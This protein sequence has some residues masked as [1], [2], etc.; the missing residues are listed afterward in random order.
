M[1]DQ[2][3]ASAQ[4]HSTPVAGDSV[5]HLLYDL[6]LRSERGA[7][8]R[9][10]NLVILFGVFMVLMTFGFV[11]LWMR[12]SDIIQSSQSAQEAGYTTRRMV[13][14]RDDHLDRRINHLAGV[15]VKTNELLGVQ[16]KS[17]EETTRLLQQALVPKGQARPVSLVDVP[18]AL[19]NIRQSQRLAHPQKSGSLLP[20]SKRSRRSLLADR[21]PVVAPGER[22]VA[23]DVHPPELVPYK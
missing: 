18:A 5:V 11:S 1:P 8:V 16:T 3:H 7:E 23:P 9:E 19:W 12:S 2:T 13:S 6:A 15:M 17:Q 10:R 20:R 14:E 22:W 4:E 21:R